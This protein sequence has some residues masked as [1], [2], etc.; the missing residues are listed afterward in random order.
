MAVRCSC[1]PD[2]RAHVATGVHQAPA[3]PD[4]GGK[5]PPPHCEQLTYVRSTSTSCPP[6]VC[7]LRFARPRECL[8][9]PHCSHTS[10]WLAWLSAAALAWAACSIIRARRRCICSS[11]A[12]SIS[13]S[14][15]CGWAALHCATEAKVSSPC[16][17]QRSCKSSGCILGFSLLDSWDD[18]FPL[19]QSTTSWLIPTS[20]R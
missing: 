20:P 11:T 9:C 6:C 15:A 13:A 16:S 5:N 2:S 7:H 14:V 10:P 12:C 1:S 8:A 3:I 18:S 19:P 17:F 4:P